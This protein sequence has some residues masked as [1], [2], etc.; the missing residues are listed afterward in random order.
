MENNGTQNQQLCVVTIMFPV[1]SDDQAIDYKK[2][3]SAVVA[4]ISDARIEFRLTNASS[5]RPVGPR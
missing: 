2:K 4:P 3:L 5:P 1:D